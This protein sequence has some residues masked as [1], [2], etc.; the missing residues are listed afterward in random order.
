MVDLGHVGIDNV[1]QMIGVLGLDGDQL[2]CFQGE[3]KVVVGLAA[4]DVVHE[5]RRGQL[6][7]QAPGH[8]CIHVHLLVQRSSAQVQL[9]QGTVE[10]AAV[11]VV[12]VRLLHR[13][14]AVRDLQSPVTT[15]R[16]CFGY[17][18]AI[19]GSVAEMSKQVR[20]PLGSH[21]STSHRPSRA[22][23]PFC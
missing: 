5:G 8:Q 13:R 2:A 4:V 15:C 20:L 21:W 19:F 14:Q 10:A 17:S 16:W 18:F 3:H 9:H 23:F 11:D 12:G 6:H 1:P 7:A 22:P